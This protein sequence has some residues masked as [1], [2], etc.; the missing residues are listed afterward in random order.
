MET[1]L[2]ITEKLFP[3][4]DLKTLF[5]PAASFHCLPAAPQEAMPMAGSGPVKGKGAA[6]TFWLE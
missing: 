1:V 4:Y 3:E 2:L 6:N 5:I